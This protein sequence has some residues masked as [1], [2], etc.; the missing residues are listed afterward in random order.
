MARL[1][2]T[3]VVVVPLGSTS[4]AVTL[5]AV[6]GPLLVT[7]TVAVMVW[8]GVPLAVELSVIAR[9]ARLLMLSTAWLLL[10][11]GLLSA[12]VVVT[13]PVLVTLPAPPTT[14]LKV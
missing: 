14:K 10:L 9:S 6:L 7:V 5:L 3:S 12:V 8:P 11:A 2:I 13:W 1:P 4:V